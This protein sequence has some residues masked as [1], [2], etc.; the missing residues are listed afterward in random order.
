VIGDNSAYVSYLLME[1]S[2]N[3]ARMGAA[4][5]TLG[6]DCWPDVGWI[7][8]R[9][10]TLGAFYDG[11]TGSVGGAE[12][13]G[14]GGG[15]LLD[16]AGGA[17]AFGLE[18]ACLWRNGLERRRWGLGFL[19]W[20]PV[21]GLR[22]SINIVLSFNQNKQTRRLTRCFGL[23][24]GFAFGPR[25]RRRPRLH[26]AFATCCRLVGLGALGDLLLSDHLLLLLAEFL[27]E[28]FWVFTPGGCW[29]PGRL[30]RR[31]GSRVGSRADLDFGCRRFRPRRRRRCRR[32]LRP[33]RFA[34]GLAV[35][36]G[37]RARSAWAAG[38]SAAVAA[39]PCRSGLR[40]LAARSQKDLGEALGLPMGLSIT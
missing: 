5:V 13:G 33:L 25:G 3:A 36:S 16:C 37:G 12:P 8:Y 39:G 29:G 20:R 32:I 23:C 30:G 40:R 21:R 9:A 11:V 6:H 4:R 24:E 18:L 22:L 34:A 15:E 7:F 14:W 28:L 1:R 2:V 35:G 17:G 31:P 27:Q 38:M 19:L 26:R 10:G